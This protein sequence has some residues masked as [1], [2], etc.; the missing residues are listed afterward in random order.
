MRRD[1]H[2]DSVITASLYDSGAHTAT[3]GM[4]VFIRR[5]TQIHVELITM[6][7]SK[8]AGKRKVDSENRQFNDEWTEKYAFILPLSSTKPMC[9]ICQK[10]VALVKSQNVK[11]HYVTEHSSFKR[12]FPPN[13]EIR[14]KYIF[15]F[16]KLRKSYQDSTK[17]IVTFM[18]Q[19]QKATE[20]SLKVAWVLGKHK[21]PTKLKSL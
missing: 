20:C 4:F 1:V 3:R 11:R 16:K 19:Q 5:R 6:A 10:T 14:A 12:D 18:T 9:L 21:K 2:R 7:C 8:L 17:K 13:T 15:F